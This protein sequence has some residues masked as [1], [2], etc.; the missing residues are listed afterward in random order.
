MKDLIG[1]NGRPT[2]TLIG[3][4]HHLVG[5]WPMANRYIVLWAMLQYHHS[6]V[7]GSA[8][9]RHNGAFS[10]SLL[11]NIYYLLSQ[12]YALAKFQPCMPT[13]FGVTALQS[14]NNRK[15]DLYSKYWENKL[16][17]LTKMA[18]TYKRNS[19]QSCNLH[20]HV[21]HELGNPLL[22]KFFLLSP[23]FTTYRDEISEERPIAYDHFNM[24]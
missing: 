2:A 11:L 15:I 18:A 6:Y 20:R 16:Q 19:V 13:T 5:K 7:T 21:C 14:R 12:V 23:F 24:T 4:Q 10:N 1:T 17:A 22:G 8:K 3:Q 9:T